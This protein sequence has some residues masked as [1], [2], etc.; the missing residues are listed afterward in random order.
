MHSIVQNGVLYLNA[1]CLFIPQ[2]GM[3]SDTL[4][5]TILQNAIKY[6]NPFHS[7]EHLIEFYILQNGMH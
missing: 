1:F 5:H 3:C 2:H 7:A 4:L 6:L